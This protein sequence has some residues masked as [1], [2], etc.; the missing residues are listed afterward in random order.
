MK[1]DPCLLLVEDDLDIS[2]TLKLILESEGYT[3]VGCLNGKLA[4]DWLSQAQRPPFLI[5]LDLMMPVMNGYEFLEKKSELAKPIRDIPVVVLSAMNHSSTPSE[6]VQ[7]YLRKP[8]DIH[9]LLNTVKRFFS[10]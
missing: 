7:A 9:F 6:R 1:Q 10:P 4:L 8:V 3:V 2:E 5:L